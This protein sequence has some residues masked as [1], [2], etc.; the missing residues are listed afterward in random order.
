M[1]RIG[2]GFRAAICTEFW[3]VRTSLTGQFKTKHLFSSGNSE[4]GVRNHQNVTRHHYL[5]SHL[6]RARTSRMFRVITKTL[7]REIENIGSPRKTAI[8]H[9]RSL[10][11]YEAT[12]TV[13]VVS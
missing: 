7:Q 10:P 5:N 12:E 1:K 2:L 13:E 11:R 3:T 8:N 6:P 4:T 9:L